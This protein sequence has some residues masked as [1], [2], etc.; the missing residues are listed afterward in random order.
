MENPHGSWT[1]ILDSRVSYWR[2]Y[3]WQLWATLPPSSQ[4]E[5]CSAPVRAVTPVEKSF[6]WCQKFQI[7]QKTWC[8]RYEWTFQPEL[9]GSI[10]I[11]R[12]RWA[13]SWDWVKWGDWGRSKWRRLFMGYVPES[14][15][16]AF[17]SGER[18][19]TPWWHM[20][21][22]HSTFTPYCNALSTWPSEFPV[23]LS[24]WGLTR[25]ARESRELVCVAHC[26]IPS[27]SGLPP[28]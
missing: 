25:R 28:Q 10:L 15:P 9:V 27:I 23:N 19:H 4:S 17:L 7:L 8:D 2:L 3:S 16:L 6:I 21:P 18:P 12:K 24:Y 22:H 11:T 20:L 13:H 5:R 26:C 14:L 1:G